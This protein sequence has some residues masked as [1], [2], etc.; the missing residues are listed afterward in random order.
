M[1]IFNE[2]FMID[3]K[4]I[5]ENPYNMTRMTKNIYETLK[6][7][8]EQN[9]FIGAILVRPH[10]L[11]KDKYEIIDGDKRY[12]ILK[13]LNQEKI[14]CIVVETNDL[15]S[16]IT[17]IRI[18]REHGYFNR[19]KTNEVI[20]DLIQKTNKL[21]IREILSCDLKEFD[22]LIRDNPRVF[23]KDMTIDTSKY[24]NI[25]QE[26]EKAKRLFYD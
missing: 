4:K 15:N 10:P 6:K 3:S 14:P 17:M 11:K 13:E 12:K 8:I 5:L 22:D 9:G 25:L 23:E 26:S 16:V 20:D 1:K 2:I 19:E 7:D 18:N 24:T 21:F